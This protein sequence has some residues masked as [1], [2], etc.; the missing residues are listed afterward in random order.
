MPVRVRY[1]M[2]LKHALPSLA[3]IA[4]ACGERAATCATYDQTY[5]VRVALHVDPSGDA[6]RPLPGHVLASVSEESSVLACKEGVISTSSPGRMLLSPRAVPL[7]GAGF[8]LRLSANTY[9]QAPVS[10]LRLQVLVDENENGRCD[11]GEP[12]GEAALARAAQSH[13]QLTLHRA[14]CPHAL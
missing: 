12:L 7:E 2:R 8:T 5:R 4:C 6:T 14:P 11:D 3:L 1:C 10:S 13:V 9:A